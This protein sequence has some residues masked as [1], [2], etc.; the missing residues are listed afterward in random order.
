MNKSRVF[1]WTSALRSG[2]YQQG[3]EYLQSHDCYC[4]LGVLAHIVNDEEC[5]LQQNLSEQTLDN[6][7]LPI[8]G[9]HSSEGSIPGLLP[10][11]DTDPVPVPRACDEMTLANLN[12]GVWVTQYEL[13]YMRAKSKVIADLTDYEVNHRETFF[14]DKVFIKLNFEQIADIIEE[15]G[16]VI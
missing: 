15:F 6:D 14:K 3:E 13:G 2:S 10:P 11:R 7:F 16:E 1:Q 8:C 4:C 5:G 12:D 9:I